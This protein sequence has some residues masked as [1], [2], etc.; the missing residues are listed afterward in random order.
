MK[1][2]TV[3]GCFEAFDISRIVLGTGSAMKSLSKKQV[4]AVFDAYASKGGNVFDT[5][6]GYCGGDSERYIGEWIRLH[7][8]RRQMH[9][10]T[11][12]CHAFAGEPSRL[13]REDFVKLNESPDYELDHFLD[14]L[15]EKPRVTYE[16]TGD[17]ALLAMV[18]RGLGV[19]IVHDLILH[20]RRYRVVRL[21]LDVTQFRDVGV[22]F[23]KD[24]EPSLITKLF[25]EHTLSC[26]T[27]L[28]NYQ[29]TR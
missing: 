23:R 7:D 17:F 3:R 22:A 5:A 18:E 12:A 19:S 29:E 20:P 28:D 25:I 14:T 8:C 11:K 9:I 1:H 15:P 6:P 16:A 10:S 24:A 21:P 27:Q 4:F 2:L 26:K 13:T